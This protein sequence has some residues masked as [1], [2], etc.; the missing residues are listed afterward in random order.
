MEKR[1]G[2][3]NVH[4]CVL[5]GFLPGGHREPRN[6]LGF[7]SAA[8]RPRKFEPDIECLISIIQSPRVD[9]LEQG[10]KYVQS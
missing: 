2:T 9:S 7:L 3:V 8:E 10:V 1:Q 4:H 5:L 6:K